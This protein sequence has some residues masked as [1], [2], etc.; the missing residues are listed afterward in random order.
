MAKNFNEDSSEG[1]KKG[2]TVAGQPAI[3]EWTK[4]S[5]RAKVSMLVGDRFI[6]HVRVNPAANIE[7]ASSVAQQLDLAK[8]AVLKPTAPPA[9]APPTSDK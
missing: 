4:S 5:Q 9:P 6:V 8:L 2:G 1:I 3:L 7:A